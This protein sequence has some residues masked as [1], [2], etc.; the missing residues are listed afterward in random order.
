MNE[1][2]INYPNSALR[3]SMLNV[4]GYQNTASITYTPYLDYIKAS[5]PGRRRRD[6]YIRF[7]IE[8][9]TAFGN[10][11]FPLVQEYINSLIAVPKHYYFDDTLPNSPPKTT[12]VKEIVLIILKVWL[13]MQ[14]YTT[15]AHNDKRCIIKAYYIRQK[16]TPYNKNTALSN[17]LPDHVAKS[18]LLPNPH[19]VTLSN[20]SLS[21]A[22]TTPRPETSLHLHTYFGINKSL[23]ITPKRLNDIK[24]STL[25]GV[26]FT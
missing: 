17:H 11:P 9:V 2:T 20:S 18:G 19:E 5:W 24:L 16:L 13:L 8:V 26:K 4:L 21:L 14:L 22:D 7:C 6:N 25:G 10:A 3:T 1:V 12:A 15:P 23:S